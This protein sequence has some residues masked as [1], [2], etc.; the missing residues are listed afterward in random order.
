MNETKLLGNRIP[1]DYF[2]TKG[3]GES[4]ITIHAGSFHLALK[5]AGIERANIMS[6]SSIMPGIAREIKQPIDYAHGEVME[7]I[8]S[9]GNCHKGERISVGIIHGWLYNKRTQDR[10]GGLVCERQ[11]DYS[12][13]ELEEQ[14]HLS[15]QELYSNGFDEDYD[16]R[17]IRIDTETISPKKE[18]GTALVAICFVNHVYPQMEKPV[19]MD[20]MLKKVIE[21][22]T[23]KAKQNAKDKEL[24]EA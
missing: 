6:Y 4:D 19:E 16:L 14:L 21:Q 10:M 5:E 22:A 9:V 2:I 18:Y 20:A 8:L 11:G 13:D 1:R 7:S 24:A 17:D 15:L 12:I 23:E 3:A